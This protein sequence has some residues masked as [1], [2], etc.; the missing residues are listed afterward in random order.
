MSHLTVD[1]IISFVSMTEIN[2][3]TLELSAVVNQH[4]CECKK[5]YELVNNFQLVY[6]EFSR[7]NTKVSFIDY[8][9]DKKMV[10]NTED[11]EESL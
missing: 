3:E 8:V 2:K 4:I 1:K 6:D 10:E 7:M 11:F 5:C 9:N